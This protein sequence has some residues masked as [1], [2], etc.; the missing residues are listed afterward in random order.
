MDIGR[1]VL[2]SELLAAQTYVQIQSDETLYP[3]PF[4]ADNK[5]AGIVW[6][7]K[8]A[9]ESFIGT[10]TIHIHKL[11]LAPFTPITEVEELLK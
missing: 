2:A 7:T 5:V 8:V 11:H 4:G 6:S 10:E 9:H 3:D 1:L